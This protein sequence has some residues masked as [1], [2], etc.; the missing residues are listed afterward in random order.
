LTFS[1]YLRRIAFWREDDSLA[2]YLFLVSK[3]I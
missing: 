3:I 2:I 1:E